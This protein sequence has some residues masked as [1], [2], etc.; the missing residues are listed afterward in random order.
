MSGQWAVMS[1]GMP[2]LHPMI[3]PATAADKSGSA[4]GPL[5]QTF[6]AVAVDSGLFPAEHVGDLADMMDG[7]LGA[8]TEG[9]HWIVRTGDEGQVL[10]AAYSEAGPL[11][12]ISS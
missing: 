4:P 7:Q 5:P 9:Q 10:A 1:G 12:P 8:E 2:H 3:R 6:A 11:H